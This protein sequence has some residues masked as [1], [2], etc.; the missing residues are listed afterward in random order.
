M[1]IEIQ[2]KGGKNWFAKAVGTSEKYGL[3]VEFL[4]ATR[5]VSRSLQYYTITEPGIYKHEPREAVC[6]SMRRDTGF[7][8]VDADGTV[9]EISKEEAISAFAKMPEVTGLN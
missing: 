5:K 4:D 1:N 7:L 2:I 3:K 9:T 8:R 6:L